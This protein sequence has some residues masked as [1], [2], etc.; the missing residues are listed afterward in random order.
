MRYSS[1]GLMT[2]SNPKIIND[3]KPLTMSFIPTTKGQSV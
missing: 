3:K 1:K 2:N